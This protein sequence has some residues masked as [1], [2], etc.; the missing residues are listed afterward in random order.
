M[1]AVTTQPDLW[2]GHSGA[3]LCTD[4]RGSK[5]S[6]P[7]NAASALF[8]AL[9]RQPLARALRYLDVLTG[10]D[11]GVSQLDSARIRSRSG[12]AYQEI[13][14][15][16]DMTICIFTLK[17][18]A[19][20]PA[21]DHPGMHVFGRLLYGQMRVKSWDLTGDDGEGHPETLEENKPLEAYYYG[22]EVVGPTPATYGLAPEE[23]NIH[24]IEALED[25]AFF[26][27]LTPPYKPG[28][29][30]DCSYFDT[31]DA[32]LQ[33]GGA[34]LRMVRRPD[35]GMESTEDLRSDLSYACNSELLSRIQTLVAGHFAPHVSGRS[36]RLVGQE[37]MTDPCEEGNLCWPAR[38]KCF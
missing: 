25:C 5:P 4:T 27:I 32:D 2:Q 9:R 13:Y 31:T 22:E 34:F 24:Q 15:G 38:P 6:K 35:F 10:A 12:V 28:G 14:C 20:I 30:R 7:R 36:A 26:D 21:H 18:G 29:G 37:S 8:R 23:G 1:T 11:L 16:S 17:K 33:P 19:Q 3:L